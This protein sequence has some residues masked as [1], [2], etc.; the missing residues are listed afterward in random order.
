MASEKIELDILTMQDLF[1][2]SDTNLK[3]LEQELAVRLVTRDGNVEVTG[4]TE[5]EIHL[6]VQTLRMLNQIR[7]I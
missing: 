4:Q 6:A 2:I 1:G 5:E 7:A 3:L